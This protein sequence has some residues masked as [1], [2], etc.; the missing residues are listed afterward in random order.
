VLL[1]EVTAS[2]DAIVHL[3][4]GAL[5]LDTAAAR[6]LLKECDLFQAAALAYIRRTI[7]EIS[8]IAACNSL[9]SIEQRLA[10]WLLQTRQRALNSEFDITH[11]L[12]AQLLSVR[13]ASV[14]DALNRLSSA[15]LICVSRSKIRI[16]DRSRLE[17]ASCECYQ[18]ISCLHGGMRDVHGDA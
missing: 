14:T 2:N 13:R 7:R 16:V 8:Q 12:I 6:A 15:G 4:G 3:A 1:G 17:D 10:R 18:A 11:D 9:H 5:C